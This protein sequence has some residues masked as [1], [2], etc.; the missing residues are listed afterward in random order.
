ME[1]YFLTF[2]KIFSLNLENEIDTIKKIATLCGAALI[3][4]FFISHLLG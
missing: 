4:N 1:M 2:S 3:I